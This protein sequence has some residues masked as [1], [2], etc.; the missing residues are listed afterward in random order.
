[1]TNLNVVDVVGTDCVV[2]VLVR[3]FAAEDEGFAG[4][5]DAG[6][7]ADANDFGGDDAIG[8][9]V[10]CGRGGGLGGVDK[11][12]GVKEVVGFGPGG[13]G[14]GEVRGGGECGEAGVF[15]GAVGGG[16]ARGW[17]RHG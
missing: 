17:M 4:S 14:G 16:G 6:V 15:G 9:G 5:G 13:L 11:L 3:W 2:V 7:V 10:L 8:E 12:I 1:M